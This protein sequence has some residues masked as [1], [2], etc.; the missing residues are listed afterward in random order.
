MV[1]INNRSNK[2]YCTYSYEYISYITIILLTPVSLF[3]SFVRVF[4]VLAGDCV[5]NPAGETR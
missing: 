4:L 2:Q 1:V 5:V 3:F